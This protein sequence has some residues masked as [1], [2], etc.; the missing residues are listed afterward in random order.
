[1]IRR[2]VTVDAYAGVRAWEPA[3]GIVAGRVVRH[4]APPLADAAECSRSSSPSRVGFAARSAASPLTAP[5]GRPDG[6]L[7]Q[8]RAGL[9]RVEGQGCPPLVVEI[10]TKRLNTSQATHGPIYR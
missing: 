10:A 2:G 3:C 1:G 7:R 9:A 8:R 5:A 4:M 6:L